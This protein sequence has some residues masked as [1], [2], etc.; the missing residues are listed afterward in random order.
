MQL[1]FEH[2][3]RCISGE[4]KTYI[5]TQITQIAQLIVIQGCSKFYTHMMQVKGTL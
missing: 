3:S 5:G 4:E 2:I 1:E